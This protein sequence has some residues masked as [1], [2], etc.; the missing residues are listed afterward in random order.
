MLSKK[1]KE[2]YGTIKRFCKLF[3]LNYQSFRNCLSNKNKCYKSQIEALK[4]AKF[5]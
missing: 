4:K 3:N 5:I 1:I 2:K